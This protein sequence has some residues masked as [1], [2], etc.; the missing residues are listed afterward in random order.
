MMNVVDG[1]PSKS[2]LTIFLGL[3]PLSEREKQTRYRLC[4]LVAITDSI[5]LF[6]SFFVGFSRHWWAVSG[7][8]IFVNLLLTLW[9]FVLIRRAVNRGDLP[10]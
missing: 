8:L 9:Y 1:S 2:K 10:R 3:V 6:V 5:L 4:S 7:T